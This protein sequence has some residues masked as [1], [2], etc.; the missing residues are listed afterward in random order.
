MVADTAFNAIVASSGFVEAAVDGAGQIF[1][2]FSNSVRLGFAKASEF[3]GAFKERISSA[4]T[5]VVENVQ[6]AGSWIWDHFPTKAKWGLEEVAWKFG[7]FKDTAGEYLSL[8]GQDAQKAWF[9]VQATMGR[10]SSESSKT[11]NRIKETVGGALGSIAEGATQLASTVGPAL[12]ETGGKFVGLGG[13]YLAVI[14]PRGV[15]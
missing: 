10:F 8:W 1:T 3:G 2:G 7:Q 12:L 15:S 11:F 13:P 5:G 4:M 14:Q 9:D 6:S